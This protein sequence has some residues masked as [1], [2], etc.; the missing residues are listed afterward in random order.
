MGL[1]TLFS[2]SIS[3]MG[4][5]P[6]AS[7]NAKASATLFTGPAGTP[8]SRSSAN[9]S[10]DVF[11][12]RVFQLGHEIQPVHHARGIR[13]KP[14]L[15]SQILPVHAAAQRLVQRVVARR[16]GDGSVS[17]A[18]HFVGRNGRV[19]IAL[20]HPDYARV[21]VRRGLIDQRR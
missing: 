2:P 10:L 17:G 19:L 8:A 14:R 12:Q 7:A 15:G 4:A 11:V 13:G 1:R 16:D 20:R 6:S 9:H 3:T 21:E 18:E 5:R